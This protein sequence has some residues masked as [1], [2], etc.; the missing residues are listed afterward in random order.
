MKVLLII[1]F[2]L[3]G[4]IVF[5]IV[6][7][8]IH[9]HKLVKINKGRDKLSKEDFVQY[10]LTKGYN[11][12]FISIIYNEITLYIGL[13]DFV[14]L[15]NDDLRKICDLHDLDDIELIDRICHELGVEK[16][17]QASFDSINNK[18]DYLSFEYLLDLTKNLNVLEKENKT[19]G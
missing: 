18:Y 14:L 4:A 1:L 9:K 19:Y 5:G 7:R 17:N 13:K 2:I 16:P 15:P 6:E 8:N 3:V 12:D 11:Y 10:F